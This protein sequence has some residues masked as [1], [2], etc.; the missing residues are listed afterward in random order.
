MNTP[1]SHNISSVSSSDKERDEIR[2]AALKIIMGAKSVSLLNYEE[3]RHIYDGTA[4]IAQKLEL[5]RSYQIFAIEKSRGLNAATNR[6]DEIYLTTPLLKKWGKPVPGKE[7][8]EAINP[9]LEALIAHELAHCTR[10]QWIKQATPLAVLAGAIATGATTSYS[11]NELPEEHSLA[12]LWKHAI[13]AIAGMAGAQGIR[14]LLSETE[15]YWADQKAMKVIDDPLQ[16]TT[17]LKIIEED[18]QR[19]LQNI[20]ASGVPAWQISAVKL[21][22]YILNPHPE[23]DDRIKAIHERHSRHQEITR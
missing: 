9:L 12:P 16:L 8:A 19:I 10:P 2:A 11:L 17:A 15:E 7:E 4:A 13:V 22:D 23:T 3:W 20:R 21:F 14:N 1:S 5:R 6:D 18:Q